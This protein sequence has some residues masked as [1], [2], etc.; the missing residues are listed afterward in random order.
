MLNGRVIWIPK[1]F[2]LKTDFNSVETNRVK[3]LAVSSYM[4]N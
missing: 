2:Y 1:N 4:T 3:L